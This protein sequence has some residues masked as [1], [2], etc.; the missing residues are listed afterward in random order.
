MLTGTLSLAGHGTISF[1]VKP[2]GYQHGV[3]A[4]I[5]TPFVRET[6]DHTDVR[7][8]LS[9]ISSDINVVQE[10][11]EKADRSRSIDDEV[12]LTLQLSGLEIKM[13][14]FAQMLRKKMA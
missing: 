8:A 11:I 9:D 2:S 3:R 13:T 1:Q 10:L 14:N 5:T 12:R 6:I 4:M 7:N